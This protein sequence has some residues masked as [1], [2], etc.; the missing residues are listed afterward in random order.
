MKMFVERMTIDNFKGISHLEL[1]F[2][3][4]VTSISGANGSGKSSVADAFAWCLLGK[5]IAGNAPGLDNFRIKPLDEDGNE[6]HNL[7]TA[8]EVAA[9][10]DGEPF[11][12]KRQLQEN[13]V[14][15][16]GSKDAVFQGD[17]S[18]FWINGVPLKLNEYNA[19]I[20][21]QICPKTYLI[22]LTI[23]GAFNAAPVATR[24][25]ILL[26]L[27]SGDVDERLLATNEY[28]PLHDECV[29]RGVTIA[30]LKKAL[31]GSQREANSALKIYPARID[32]ARR[33]LPELSE[34]QIL[35]AEKAETEIPEKLTELATRMSQ[36]GSEAKKAS[37]K[38]EVDR[39]NSEL[40]QMRSE[41][42]RAWN[43]EFLRLRGVIQSETSITN[44]LTITL[45]L[46]DKEISAKKLQIQSLQKG[47]AEKR[48]EYNRVYYEAY[49]EPEIDDHCPTCGQMLPA[50]QIEEVRAADEARWLNE[51]KSRLEQIVEQGKK[52]SED[53]VKANDELKALE[54]DVADLKEK[55]EP[56]FTELQNAAVTL[57]AMEE[58]KDE[59]LADGAPE[60]DRTERIASLLTDLNAAPDDEMAHLTAEQKTLQEALDR[61]H[62]TLALR[63]NGESIL[64]RIGQLEEEQRATGEVLTDIEQKLALCDKYTRDRCS[65]LEE[66]INELFPTLRWQLFEIQ[67]NGGVKDKCMAM[68]PCA[69][70]LIPYGDATGG[71]A[72]TAARM[73]AD[74]E[75]IEVLSDNLGRWLPLFVDRAESI[76]HMPTFKGQLIT[77]TVSDSYELRVEAE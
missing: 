68:I 44:T 45:E 20:E 32:E 8:V 16:R 17:N 28:A 29:T 11:V 54:D 53:L 71:S 31:Q 39:L 23:L 73:S 5:D 64:K 22:Y 46:R 47:I 35:E 4:T 43:D 40:R 2:G 41:K 52:A 63:D 19:R 30:D 27:V 67:D 76:N 13:W 69:S 21:D 75:I 18:S 34:S 7:T 56:H 77:L 12:L 72:N 3:K 58:T 14:R 55:C 49:V 61:A 26:D 66:S 65:Y 42:Q 1:S 48:A 9:R 36:C 62:K 33:S 70:G 50:D 51:K 15:K 25:S 57:K 6:M 60:M 24:R 59:A 37:V 74:M 38:A 10:V